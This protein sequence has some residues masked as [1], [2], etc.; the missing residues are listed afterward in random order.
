MGNPVFTTSGTKS[1][2]NAEARHRGHAS[3]DI[4]SNFTFVEVS[5]VR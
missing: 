1:R 2:I 5:A 3:D 4:M